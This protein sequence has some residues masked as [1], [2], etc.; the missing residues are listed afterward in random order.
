MHTAEYK[1]QIGQT[2]YIVDTVDDELKSG[3]VLQATIDI[4]QES[5]GGLDFENVYTIQLLT[6]L[7][8]SENI[9]CPERDVYETLAEAAAAL[10]SHVGDA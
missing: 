6:G 9:D 10:E 5:I 7:D 8:C 4:Y 1:Y 3:V 2:V